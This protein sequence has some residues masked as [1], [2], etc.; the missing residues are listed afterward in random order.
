LTWTQFDLFDHSEHNADV[1]QKVLLLLALM[2]LAVTSMRAQFEYTTNADGT[3]TLAG[4]FGPEDDVVIPSTVNGLTV[5]AVGTGAF[6]NDYTPNLYRVY[7]PITVNSI[8]DN[9]FFA[10]QSLTNVNIPNDVTNIGEDAFADCF[11]LG[12]VT[13]PP[14]VTTIGDGAFTWNIFSNITMPGNVTNIGQGIFMECVRLTNAVISD[15][16]GGP[17]FLDH[18]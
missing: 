17:L 16:R 6:E 12:A 4:Y 5:T 7:I 18:G 15:G 9:A 10:C 8:G 1:K 2:S 14:S 13:I 3:L 11:V